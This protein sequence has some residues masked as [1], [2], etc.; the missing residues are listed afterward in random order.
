MVQEIPSLV[1][2]V[3]CLIGCL[4]MSH[5][6]YFR[7]QLNMELCLSSIVFCAVFETSGLPQLT[8][9]IHYS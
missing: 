2:A 8:Q 4:M 3:G 5:L 6:I 9:T 1:L 7:L